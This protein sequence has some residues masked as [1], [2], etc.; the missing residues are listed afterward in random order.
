MNSGHSLAEMRKSKFAL[1]PYHKGTEW[2]DWMEM[3]REYKNANENND[4][5]KC[6]ASYNSRS[7]ERATSFVPFK[8]MREIKT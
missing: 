4:M 1:F 3:N 8:V 7:Y 2:L 6:I 5:L